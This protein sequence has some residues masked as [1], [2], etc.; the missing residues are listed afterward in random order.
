LP[1]CHSYR[2]TTALLPRTP[3]N[4]LS[5]GANVVLVVLTA[6]SDHFSGAGGAGAAA[7]ASVLPALRYPVGDE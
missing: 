4:L 5:A 3:C 2:Y 7:D 1:C 6:C